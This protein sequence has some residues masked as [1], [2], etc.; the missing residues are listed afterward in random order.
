MNIAN[1]NVFAPNKRLQFPPPLSLG[2]GGNA[3]HR[4]F[5]PKFQRQ[6]GKGVSQHSDMFGQEDLLNRHIHTPHPVSFFS[7]ADLYFDKT[8]ICI[9]KE[10][11]H[12]Q[13][14]LT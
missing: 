4:S 2:R 3:L 5:H 8:D 6:R 14:N 1:A 12:C 9:S 13:K 11:F 10:I 7:N